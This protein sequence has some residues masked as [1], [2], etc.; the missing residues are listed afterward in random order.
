MPLCKWQKYYILISLFI[1]ECIDKSLDMDHYIQCI[2]KII[3]I[4]HV[5]F[6]CSLC[7]TDFWS[8]ILILSQCWLFRYTY[9]QS[10]SKW[11]IRLE[12]TK[13]Q[14]NQLFYIFQILWYITKRFGGVIVR[15]VPSSMA[16][17]GVQAMVRSNNIATISEK[18]LPGNL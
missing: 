18:H 3:I 15:V 5:F 12:K 6:W 13:Q 17:Q 1:V 2:Y 4:C 10:V 8:L 11:S 16:D 9:W 7:R 14:T